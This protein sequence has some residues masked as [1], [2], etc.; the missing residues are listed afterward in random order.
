M[1][2]Q[3][4]LGVVVAVLDHQQHPLL[5]D[6]LLD[7]GVDHLPHVFRL[8]RC[9]DQPVLEVHRQQVGAQVLLRQLV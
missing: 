6:H 2:L 1:D 8:V 5:L 4:L 7:D 9:G 3:H